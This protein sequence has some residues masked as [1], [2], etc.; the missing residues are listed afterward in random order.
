LAK[1]DPRPFLECLLFHGENQLAR[2]QDTVLS[3]EFPVGGDETLFAVF[4]RVL[5]KL[6]VDRG[7][8]LA[9]H[10]RSERGW[11][12]ALAFLA[13]GRVA[14]RA[15]YVDCFALGLA[16][17]DTG[18]VRSTLQALKGVRDPVLLPHYR[19]LVERFPQERDHV[20]AHLRDRF[21]E[22]GLTPSGESKTPVPTASTTSPQ[23]PRPTA[24]GVASWWRR[25]L[26]RR[27]G[28]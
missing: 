1:E 9:L 2:W 22:F 16:D 3:P 12:R 8:Y 17:E 15:R 4:T 28:N 6:D 19:R 21:A 11:I 10:T 20:L 5:D 7:A 14:D 25:L 23:A 26:G 18:V 27:P 13:L 24:S